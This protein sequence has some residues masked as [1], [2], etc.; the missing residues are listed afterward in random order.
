MPPLMIKLRHVPALCGSLMVAL[1]AGGIAVASSLDDELRNIVNE[2]KLNATPAQAYSMPSAD[3]PVARLG[4]KLFFTKNL[5]GN[6][7]AACASCHHPVLGGGDALS[8]SIGTDSKLHDVLGPGRKPDESHDDYDGGP[9]VPR[10]APTT[11]NVGLWQN[12][13]FHDGRLERTADGIRSPLSPPLKNDPRARANLVATQAL[14]P[15]TSRHEMRGGTFVNQGSFDDLYNEIADRLRYLPAVDPDRKQ[16]NDR[17][18]KAFRQA[19]ED[20]SRDVTEVITYERIADSL[21]EYQRSQVFVDSPW[22]KWIQGDNKAISDSAKRGAKIFFSKKSAGG[23][24][25]A[26]CHS[27]DTFTDEKFHALAMPQIGRGKR[28]RLNQSTTDDLGRYHAS[29]DRADFHKFRT[30]SLLNVAVTGPWSHAGAYTTLEDVIWHHLDPVS[31]LESFNTAQIDQS[32]QT[33]DLQR[34]KSNAIKSFNRSWPDN[35]WPLSG[36]S[37]DDDSVADL[38]AFLNALTDPCTQSRECLKPW[39]PNRDEADPDDQPLIAVDQAGQG[40]NE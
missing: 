17:W 8:L 29:T 3:D 35:S 18:L 22:S 25:C 21:G 40:L 27:G 13:L 11:F 36:V 9:N 26:S 33:Q 7:D 15:V 10:N 23:A 39:L 38:V 34:N 30:P 32:I 19:F 37:L 24:N 5:S 6:K 20:P 4:K 14:F 2:L 1:L 31:S 12:I 28:V 16:P